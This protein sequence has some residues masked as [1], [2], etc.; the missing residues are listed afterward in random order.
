[1]MMEQDM[2]LNVQKKEIIIPIGIPLFG[3]TLQYLPATLPIVLIINK[4]VKM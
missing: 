1:M 2:D 3:E 4:R